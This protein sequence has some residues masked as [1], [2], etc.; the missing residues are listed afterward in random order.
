VIL[1]YDKQH[2]V[3]GLEWGYRAGHSI[4]LLPGQAAPTGVAICK[5]L[6]FVVLGRAYAR[7]GVG[8][9]LVPAWDFINDRWLHSRMAVLRGAEGGYAIAR[10]A[11]D[12][13]LTVSDDRGRILA[14]RSS[15]E[16]ADVLLNTTVRVGHGGT[17]YSR[18]GD[19][20][21]WLCV[22]AAGACVAAAAAGRRPRAGLPMERVPKSDRSSAIHRQLRE[23]GF[24]P[25]GRLTSSI[26][27]AGSWSSGIAACPAR[28]SEGLR[29][30]SP[31]SADREHRQL[32][33]ELYAGAGGTRRLLAAAGEVLE[34]MAARAAGELKEWHGPIIAQRQTDI[35]LVH[36]Q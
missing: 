12:G 1:E 35:G 6:D 25:V 5:D 27:R 23:E 34:A 24:L 4:G 29:L 20:F 31:A 13:L 21:A 28:T 17:F 10:V 16:S 22:V 14:E 33:F 36:S 7:A 18:T 9:L 3:P 26:H 11:T 19:W 30:R 8:L 2:L 15:S 32:L